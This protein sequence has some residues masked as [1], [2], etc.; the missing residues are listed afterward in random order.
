MKR[1]NRI[2]QTL[3]H[4]ISK[5]V[6]LGPLVFLL[7]A[8]AGCPSL[9]ENESN[10]T[11]H[12]KP[13]VVGKDLAKT[14]NAANTTVN[15]YAAL[16]T[17]RIIG[18]TTI[19]VANIA[20]LTTNFTTPL[21]PGDLVLI[22]QM[23]GATITATE[24][25]AYGTVSSYGNAGHYEFASVESVTGSQITLTCGLKN[26]YTGTTG[27]A[28][29]IRV[30][31]YTTLTITSTGSIT[32]PAWNGVTGGVV[33]V[34]A[35]T[36][37]DLSGQIDVSEKGFRGGV[38]HNN[39]SNATGVAP[40][41]RSATAT[42][43]GQKGESIAGYGSEYD[44]LWGGQYGRGAP[45]NGGGG[46]DLHNGGG[47]GGANARSGAAWS[48][49]GV[50]LQS[51][52]GSAAW[53]LDP[54]YIA[55]GN[56]RTN[57]EG[58]GRGGYSYSDSNQNALTVAPGTASW[59]GDSRREIGGLG[60]HPLDNDTAA[61]LF[62]GGG[63]G[64]GD[65]NNNAAGDGGQGGGLIFLIAGSVT[66]SGSLKANGD[67]GENSAGGTGGGDA[68]GGGGGGGTVVVRAVN[69]ASTISI[70][71]NGGEGGN[72]TNSSGPNEAEG[73][74][75]GGG[76]GFIAVAGGTPN[77][78]ANGGP[79]G[80][81]NR[82]AMSEFRSNGATAGNAGIITGN[83]T[84]FVYCGSLVAPD[85]TIL[86]YP[87]DPSPVAI[88]T[89]TF[90]STQQAVT[91][92]CKLDSATT[93]TPCASS[94]STPSLADGPHTISVQAT[95]LSG[96]VDA[97]PAVFTWQVQ[98][99]AADDPDTT[100]V[101]H[102]E[103]PS[104]TAINTFTFASNKPNVTFQCSLDSAAF[105]A[106]ATPYNT[107]SLADGSHTIQVRAVEA[108]GN[109]DTTPAIFTWQV[110]TNTAGD[111][112]TTIVTH[113][114]N[115]SATAINPFTF[116]SDKPNVTFQC[117]LDNEYFTA[118]TTPYNTPSLADGSHTF[119]VRALEANWNVD[120]TPATFTWQVQANP[121][122]DP[123][124][125]IATYPTNPSPS[126]V[127]TF[128]FTSDKPN[129][130]FQCNLDGAGFTA[131]ANPYNTP[132]LPDGSHTLEV[133]AVEA[134]GNVDTTPATYTWLV[135]ASYLDG[136]VYDGGAPIDADRLDVDQQEAHPVLLDAE[137]KKDLAGGDDAAK[138]DV[139]IGPQFDVSPKL[140]T[141]ISEALPLIDG[142]KPID[143]NADLRDGALADTQ[144]PEASG[145]EPNQ[146]APGPVIYE[147][148]AINK[149]APVV[150]TND[151]LKV[152]GSGFCNIT[153]SRSTSPA[154]FLVL[155][156]VGL[157]V[158][159]RRRR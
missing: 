34:H 131:C 103:D 101:T 97:T 66:G 62:M 12:M 138:T 73:P 29:V 15:A 116:T 28:Q 48:G 32:A 139:P 129:V 113:P 134:S 71:A 135:L 63:G 50:M 133:R 112:D 20:N 26:A 36:T 121:A 115:P 144:G 64:A 67:V 37:L 55:N 132:N 47:G 117:K 80:T 136:G 74:G 127:G 143:S 126:P 22:I 65:G 7:V 150:P 1:T 8:G 17:D 155:A 78:E 6:V 82:D 49:Q 100:I 137:P 69:I 27:K 158:L 105:V 85:T 81:T 147:D 104:I 87:A 58:G 31:Q 2:K 57:S 159:R 118:C 45:A 14:I 60:G 156:L 52:V 54:G 16:A 95:N 41:W 84:N 123:Q 110:Q 21:G 140:D 79:G 75:G 145:P 119:Q 70:Q 89:F 125:T 114:E 59:G 25:S 98:A 23:A 148:A 35:E 30:P 46:G 120:T 44:T 107:P 68:A 40:V 13:A 124:T 3:R 10:R 86:T 77:R 91:F 83:A 102:P 4:G 128:T 11:A 76:G 88:G 151:E 152:M 53:A 130:T 153:T 154:A 92:G 93:Y 51:V 33:A 109:W 72:Q 106:C 157:A 149:D 38:A 96:L 122:D 9:F 39:T 94:Y 19:T 56:A 111:P 24:T 141:E 99:N 18:D 61:R 43:G 146:D 90:G 108:S 42:V 5:A 142:G